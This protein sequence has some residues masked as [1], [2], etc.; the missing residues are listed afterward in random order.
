[1][2]VPVSHY[3]IGYNIGCIMHLPPPKV[4]QHSRTKHTLKRVCAV[5]VCVCVDRQ[6]EFMI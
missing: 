1:M 3:A 6:S 4:K 2:G 5:A